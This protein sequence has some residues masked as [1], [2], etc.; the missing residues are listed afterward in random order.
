MNLTIKAF[1]D[2]TVDE[3]FNI[4]KLRCEVFIVEQNCPY[5]DVDDADKESFHLLLRE[6]DELVAYLRI[7]PRG[8]L[9]DEVRIGRV[10][11]KY[12]HRGYATEMLKK[13]VSFIDKEFGDNCVVLEAQVYA[14]SLYE[15]C[16]FEPISDIFLED[17]IEH[18]RMKKTW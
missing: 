1:Q 6:N 18:I 4:Y 17:N 12:R 9:G 11:A 13:A 5:Q 10:V 2:L 3:L 16:G 7:I 15:N 8:V 14:R